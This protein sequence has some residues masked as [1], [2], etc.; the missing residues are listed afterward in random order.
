MKQPVWTK[1][2]RPAT[3]PK[4]GLQECH[5]P[6]AVA[7]MQDMLEQQQQQQQQVLSPQEQR[8]PFGNRHSKISSSGSS[9]NRSSMV[10]SSVT[11]A[12][13]H[14]QAPTFAA[15]GSARAAA[16]KLLQPHP[17]SAE[18]GTT[19]H[20]EICMEDKGCTHGGRSQSRCVSGRVDIAEAG[21]WQ[22]GGVTRRTGH[23]Q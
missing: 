7:G 11:G 4:N 23:P 14:S 2:A 10:A 16:F 19:A 13:Q 3:A 18:P 5:A 22:R 17:P 20:S 12:L 1:L 8:H 21:R 9:S 6:L 15:A